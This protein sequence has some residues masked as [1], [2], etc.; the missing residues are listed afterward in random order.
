MCLSVYY[1]CLSVTLLD[2]YYY[3]LYYILS[4][5]FSSWSLSGGNSMSS[6]VERL[7]KAGFEVVGEAKVIA[8]G[9]L[10]I[11]IREPKPAEPASEPSPGQ[12]PD[13]CAA[14]KLQPGFASQ[15]AEPNPDEFGGSYPHPSVLEKGHVR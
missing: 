9:F 2:F 3:F 7:I 1:L 4:G 6:V 15:P 11:I 14:L 10:T 12:E 13:I 8:P 5:I